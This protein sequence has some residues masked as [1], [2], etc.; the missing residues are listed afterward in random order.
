MLKF[1]ELVETGNKIIQCKK[2]KSFHLIMEI[3]EVVNFLKQRDFIIKIKINE[4]F[5]YNLYNNF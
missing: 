4:N 1:F 3:T 5:N 2:S